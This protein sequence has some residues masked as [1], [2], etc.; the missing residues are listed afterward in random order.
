MDT[1]PQPPP[2]GLTERLATEIRRARRVYAAAPLSIVHARTVTARIQMAR[3]QC[4]ER[5]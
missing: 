4:K 1:T 5:R 3:D 2:V